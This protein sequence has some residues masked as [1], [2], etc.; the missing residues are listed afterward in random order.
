MK[1][2]ILIVLAASILFFSC[3]DIDM[4]SE[5][6]SSE[7]APTNYVD[8]N[9]ATIKTAEIDIQVQHVDATVQDIQHTVNKLGGTLT[10]LE[11]NSNRS[12]QQE[13]PYSKDSA[14]Q[15]YTIQPEGKLKVKIPIAKADSF[16]HNMLSLHA[17]IDKMMFNEEDI[18]ETML[19][20][21]YAEQEVSV[22]DTKSGSTNATYLHLKNK[23]KFL[24]FDVTLRGLASTTKTAVANSESV[25]KPVYL[26]ALHAVESGWYSFAGFIVLLLNIW[27]FALAG[28][29]LWWM[30]RTRLIKW[31][32]ATKKI[33]SQR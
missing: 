22:A 10:H 14:Y 27:P 9:A 11:I 6:T 12:F 13:T 7:S 17:T 21:E 23:S 24:W 8:P 1:Q 33:A 25:R 5:A 28:L 2:S 15:Y 32:W 31:Q 3:S 20:R 4:K 18:N 30:Y 29:L 19:Q 26:S 16:I